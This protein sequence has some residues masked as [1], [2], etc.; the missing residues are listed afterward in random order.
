LRAERH[1]GTVAR[2]SKQFRM[3]DLGLAHLVGKQITGALINDDHD[4]VVLNVSD[5][6]RLFLTWEG[7]CCAHC[8]LAGASG[9]EA[10]DNATI[11]EVT[12]SE[13]NRQPNNG[14]DDDDGVTEKMGCSIKTTRG[15]CTLESRVEH[16]GY[17]G[18]EVLV[19]DDEPMDQYQ[20]PRYDDPED[21]PSLFPL[22]DF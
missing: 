7:D 13:W 8:F 3:K 10:L 2:M 4:L 12:P 14:K 18:G 11:L 16:N 22:K 21:Y 1:R 19:S 17:Y 20:S 6:S 9:T 15:Y 5:G